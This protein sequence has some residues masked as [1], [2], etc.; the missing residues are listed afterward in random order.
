MHN[1]LFYTSNYAFFCISKDPFF[2][3]FP[4]AFTNFNLPYNIKICILVTN[5]SFFA[6][7][8]NLILTGIA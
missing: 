6:F 7:F 1:L 3:E 2:Q 8:C 4:F 5:L